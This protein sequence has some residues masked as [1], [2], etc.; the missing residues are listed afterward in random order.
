LPRAGN[1]QR[2]AQARLGAG[3]EPADASVKREGSNEVMHATILPCMRRAGKGTREKQR[4]LR[5]THPGNVEKAVRCR[6]GSI[7]GIN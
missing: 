4:R 2:R 5:V 7:S 1:Q 3:G 6:A